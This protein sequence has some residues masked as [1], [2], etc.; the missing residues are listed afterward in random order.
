[1]EAPHLER[2]ATLFWRENGR[3]SVKP[4]EHEGFGSQP[5]QRTME[6]TLGRAQLDFDP[7]GLACTL[8]MVLKSVA[9]AER[10]FLASNRFG[11]RL[12]QESIRA[13]S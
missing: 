12:S 10:N 2:N 9:M 8:E 1:M 7:Q 11:V 6:E 4:P 13:K 3:P 5:I